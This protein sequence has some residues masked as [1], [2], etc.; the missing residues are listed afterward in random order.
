MAFEE[1]FDIEIPDTEAEKIRTVQDVIDF[2]ESA[3]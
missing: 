3:K 1:E 2:I